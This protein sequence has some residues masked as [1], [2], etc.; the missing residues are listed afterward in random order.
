[1]LEA[2]NGAEALSVLAEHPD[3]ALLF[4]DVGLP[5]G[6]NG[7]V[8]AEEARARRPALKVLFATGYA[9]NAIVH[10]GVLDSGVELL[11]KPYTVE[12]LAR[13]LQNM[14]ARQ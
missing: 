9:K 1:V 13:K 11:E 14:L 2:G 4:T 7:R 10:N 6:M 5:G 12:A 8:L 3:I